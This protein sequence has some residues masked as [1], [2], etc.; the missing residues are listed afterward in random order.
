M[1]FS[2]WTSYPDQ[3]R[4]A[5]ASFFLSPAQGNYFVDSTFEVSI[6]LNTG[7][8]SIN[9]VDA[10]LTF[11]ADKLQV[12]NPTVSKSFIE[13]WTNGP[14]Y[15]NTSGTLSFQGG[16]P[17]PGVN[18][19][20]G[21]VSTV[22]FRAKSAGKAVIKFSDSSKVLAND[23]NGTNIL[24]SKGQA[25]L[26]VQLPAPAGP[27]VSSPSH[28][29]QNKWYRNRTVTLVWESPDGAK[30][31]SYVLDNNPTTLPEQTTNITTT[32][33]STEVKSDGIWYFH[34]R[35]KNGTGWGGVTHYSL[36][37]DSTSPAS[38]TPQLERKTIAPSTRDVVKFTTTDALSGLDHY[39]VKIINKNATGSDTVFFTE[40]QSPYQLPELGLGSYQVIVRAYDVAGNYT[41]GI[42]ELTVSANNLTTSIPFFANPL[43]NNLIIILLGLILL[44]LLIFW[45]VHRRRRHEVK[46]NELQEHLSEL[47]TNV[48]TKQAELAKLVDL[49]RQSE[50]TLTGIT[51]SAAPAVEPVPPGSTSASPT[52]LVDPNNPTP[53][54]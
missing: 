42:A 40:Q 39:E 53:G 46:A 6:L 27:I 28:E 47:K 10:E 4:A 54:L 41:D 14:S 16:I 38:F 52:P 3:A 35:G 17:S 11:P 37:I 21:V 9:A 22:Q 30:E 44:I 45:W 49:K 32:Q 31:F 18:V 5:G 48:D 20:A 19:S 25:T 50:Q 13:I 24:S 33:L 12:V 51:A 36:K 43:I 34:I 15:S 7:G 29:D 1:L 2:V 23:G 8:T 26:N